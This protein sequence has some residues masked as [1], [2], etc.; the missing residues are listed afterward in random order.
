MEDPRQLT[1]HAVEILYWR[2]I[3]AP[4]GGSPSEPLLSLFTPAY[5]SGSKIHIPYGSLLQQTYSNWEWVIYDVSW[6]PTC[7]MQLPANKADKP[8]IR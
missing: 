8:A 2:T 5:K 6:A 4:I 3:H 1:A 7:C